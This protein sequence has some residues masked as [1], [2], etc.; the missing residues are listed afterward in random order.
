MGQGPLLTWLPR[1][2]RA[3]VSEG[4]GSNTAGAPAP[5]QTCRKWE[6]GLRNEALAQQDCSIHACPLPGFIFGL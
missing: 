4:R 2:A 1:A 6:P 5:R 3:G